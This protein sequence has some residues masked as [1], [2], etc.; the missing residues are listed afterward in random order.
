[1]IRPIS[2][3]L[4]LG[5]IAAN[6]GSND[7]LQSSFPWLLLFLIFIPAVSL[8]G[9]SSL[10]FIFS[11]SFPMFLFARILGSIGKYGR[12]IAFQVIVADSIPVSI[13]G[14]MMGVYNIFS[15]LGSS[16]AMM[17]S[18]LLYD[19]SPVLPFYT[20]VLAYVSAALVAVKF[21]HEPDIQQL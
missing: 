15:S 9:I 16:S 18:G 6:H 5:L 7:T 11:N 17:F 4:L 2:L 10:L 1:M 8:L 3:F 21:L 12:M 20:A 13:R 14:R 19:V